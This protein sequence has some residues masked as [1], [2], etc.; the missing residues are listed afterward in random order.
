MCG[1][2]GE[3][4]RELLVDGNGARSTCGGWGAGSGERGGEA[5]AS[6]LFFALTE[7]LHAPTMNANASSPQ[8]MQTWKPRVS[9]SCSFS[10]AS[11][12]ASTLAMSAVSLAEW[13]RR[14]AGHV[15]FGSRSRKEVSTLMLVVLTISS[16]VMYSHWS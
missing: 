9:L 16:L 11:S 5:C 7:A 4:E 8:N 6:S 14:E 13:L 15:A 2:S 1:N 12:S 10:T 3:R